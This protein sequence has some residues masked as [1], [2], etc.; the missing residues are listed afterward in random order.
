[1]KAIWKNNVSGWIGVGYNNS[2]YSRIIIVHSTDNL[3]V[4][5]YKLVFDGIPDPEIDADF[6]I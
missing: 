3:I 1:M 6:N 5:E 4:V 2:I